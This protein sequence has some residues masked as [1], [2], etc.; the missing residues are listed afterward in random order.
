L[1]VLVINAGSSSLK[2]SLVADGGSTIAD[3]EFKAAGGRFEDAE[4]ESA[5]R[6]MEGVDAVGHRVVHG[7]PR[8]PASVRITPQ[9]VDYL[10]SITDM[11]PLHMP[12]ALAGIAAVRALLPRI[13][14]VA[15]FDT[16]FHSRMPAEASTYAVPLEWRSEHGIRRYGFHGFSHAYAS[17]RVAEILGRPEAF[18]R[19]IT[20]HLGS[21]ASVAAVLGGRSVDT[22]M[23]FT[24]MEGLVMATRSG[25]VDPGMVLWLQRHAGMTEPQLND[26]LDQKSGL[27]ALAG[28]A[29][30]R[31]VLRGLTAGVERSRLAFDVYIHRL[32]SCIGAMAAAMNG[33]DAV[34]FTGGVGE[35][36]PAV[37]AA[38]VSGLRF[39]GLEL[40]PG[41]NSS[42]DEDGDIS[43]ADATARTLVVRAREDVEVA[44]EV[45]GV[46]TA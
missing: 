35:H 2:V 46:L 19:T 15:C 39:L 32:R 4:L 40:D 18:L 38:A 20:C 23:G 24:P 41:L 3:H 9:V 5:V 34:A 7:G 28:V 17:R 29:D 43:A 45:R 37:R 16:A 10:V 26:A 27:L 42:V 25:T 8:Y 1:R 6:K 21:G 30:M 11:A 44:R 13:P 36:A 22:T 33:A 12:P 14:A 31:E